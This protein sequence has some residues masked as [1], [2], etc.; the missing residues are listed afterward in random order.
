MESRYKSWGVTSYVD[1]LFRVNSP[2]LK[3]S[4]QAV[5][6]SYYTVNNF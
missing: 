2:E 6:K 5:N 1:Y 3:N 4:A